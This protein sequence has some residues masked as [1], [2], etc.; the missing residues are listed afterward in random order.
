M[1]TDGDVPGV[2]R[3][4]QARLSTRRD[5]DEVVPLRERLVIVRLG[6]HSFAAGF[7]QRTR[8]GRPIFGNDLRA[9]EPA[10]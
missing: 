7:T 5:A 3:V 4:A 8:I 2:E 6:R 10:R 9:L 1:A